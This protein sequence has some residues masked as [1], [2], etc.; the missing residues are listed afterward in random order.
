MAVQP[1]LLH[2]RWK[3]AW[4]MSSSEMLWDHFIC[5][6]LIK[7]VGR[8]TRLPWSTNDCGVFWSNS[9]LLIVC[10]GGVASVEEIMWDK[11][12]DIRCDTHTHTHIEALKGGIKTVLKYILFAVLICSLVTL[13]FD[14]LKVGIHLLTLG[15]LLPSV[16]LEYCCRV[17]LH[18]TMLQQC[19]VE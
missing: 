3:L 4:G 9:V 17:L 12:I 18:T 15:N 14:D 6:L 1:P 5:G 10:L 13:K 16:L 2:Y 19:C 7:E 8:F 11:S